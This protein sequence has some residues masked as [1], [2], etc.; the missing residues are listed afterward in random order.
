MSIFEKL[1][2]RRFDRNMTLES[3]QTKTISRFLDHLHY[4]LKQNYPIECDF[5]KTKLIGLLNYII[6]TLN[7]V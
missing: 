1:R 4:N 3:L 6:D 7:F 2:L 5:N